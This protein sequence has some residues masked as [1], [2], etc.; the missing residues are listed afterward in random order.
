[1]RV[2]VR[3]TGDPAAFIATARSIVRDLD[4]ALPIFGELTAEQ[5]IARSLQRRATY[6]WMAAV[7]AGLALVLALGGAY[8]VS[9]YLV[10]QRTREIGIRLAIGAAT[11]DIIRSVLAKGLLTATA[12]VALGIAAMLLLGGRL[13]DL[14]FGV[15]PRDP[16]V[17]G[18]CVTVLVLAALAANWIPARRAAR[19][20]AMVTLRS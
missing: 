19:T 13:S 9:S 11:G 14:L 20:D 8:G 4:P 18:M 10:T 12:G 1:M 15:S 5:A 16:L 2:V 6:S 3:T 17:L 7:F